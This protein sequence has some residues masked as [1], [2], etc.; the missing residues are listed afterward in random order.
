MAQA[1]GL[2][3]RASRLKL[4]EDVNKLWFV[5]ATNNGSL[6]TESGGTPDLTGETPVPPIL[7]QRADFVIQTGLLNQQIVARVSVGNLCGSQA[8]LRL[9]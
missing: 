9:A 7:M 5:R 4:F 8:Q 1:S 6:Q 3:F 2:S